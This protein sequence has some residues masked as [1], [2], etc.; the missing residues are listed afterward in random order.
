MADTSSRMLQLLSLLQLHRYWHGPELAERLDISLR[1]LRRDIDRLRGLGYPIESVRGVDGGYQMGVGVALAPMTFTHDEA[2][3]LAVGLRAV[4]NGT[5][6]T[7]AEASLRALAKLV[8]TLPAAVRRQVELMDH[9]T[10]AADYRRTTEQ[11]AAHVLGV[12]AQACQDEVRLRFEYRAPV[13][14]GRADVDRASAPVSVRYVEPYRLITRG[15]R[16]YMVAFDLDRTD[17]RTFR[18]D[19]MSDPSPTRNTFTPRPLPAADLAAYVAGRIRDLRQL[20]EV[21]FVV[22][23]P[24]SVVR[25][26]I[27]GPAE[28]TRVSAQRT[29]VVMS[30]DD[31]DWAMLMIFR[32]DVPVTITSPALAAHLT[33]RSSTLRTLGRT[34]RTS[35]RLV[36]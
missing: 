25:R 9:V 28:V 16:W 1:T 7:T 35:N 2:V 26:E 8:T 5:D 14:D 36:E 4:A 18:V 33:R 20:H 15:R 12:V 19:R 31:L 11:P 10:E 27:H 30:V 22:D 6:P 3:A 29:R 21:E 32:F 23:A 24:E 34:T 13:A 17:W